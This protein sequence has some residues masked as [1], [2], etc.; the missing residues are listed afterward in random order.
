MLGMVFFRF[1]RV[2]FQK[3]FFRRK[4]DELSLGVR[5]ERVVGYQSFIY[6]FRGFLVDLYDVK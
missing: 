1:Q 4:L 6:D 5:L 3:Y 2:C